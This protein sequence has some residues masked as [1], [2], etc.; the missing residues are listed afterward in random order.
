MVKIYLFPLSVG[1]NIGPSKSIATHS[2]GVS[3]IGIFLNG[4]L[5]TI[6]LAIVL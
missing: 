5:G 1:R 6:P 4:T 3:M 2:N